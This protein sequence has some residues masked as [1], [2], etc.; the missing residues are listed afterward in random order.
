MSRRSIAP[1][2]S[3]SASTSAVRRSGWTDRTSDPSA[4]V[5]LQRLLVDGELAFDVC[6]CAVY[7]VVE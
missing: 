4:R 6:V 3:M 2:H 7:R 1:R 5:S